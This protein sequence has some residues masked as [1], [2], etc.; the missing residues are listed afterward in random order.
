MV[1]LKDCK[2][3]NIGVVALA[4]TAVPCANWIKD[5]IKE[6]DGVLIFG[7]G[8][9]S[10]ELQKHIGNFNVVNS[11]TSQDEI[12]RYLTTAKTIVITLPL[13]GNTNSYFNEVLFSKIKNE[14]DIISISRGEVIS[15]PALVNFVAS[16]KLK[17][18]HFDMLTSDHRTHISQFPNIRYY[19]HVSWSYNQPIIKGK[20]GGYVNSNFADDLKNL[21]DNCKENTVED[22]YLKRHDRVWF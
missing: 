19:E 20:I 22:A 16:G 4:P 15:N 3:K 5:K 13:N 12:D 6:D 17:E 9:I 1:N 10:K 14:V 11:K 2:D 21:I 8:S 7:N 18:G